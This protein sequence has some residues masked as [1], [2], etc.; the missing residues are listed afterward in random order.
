MLN[1]PLAQIQNAAKLSIMSDSG[2]VK[3]LME[4]ISPMRFVAGVISASST[5]FSFLVPETIT[6]FIF[7]AVLFQAMTSF[8]PPDHKKPLCLHLEHR[9]G[10]SLLLSSVSDSC[11][12]GRER[13]VR[14]GTQCVYRARC[15]HQILELEEILVSYAL[16]LYRSRNKGPGGWNDLPKLYAQ[17]IGGRTKIGSPK[18]LTLD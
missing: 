8:T 7:W 9:K 17:C 11:C 3:H 5:Y 15:K 1:N 4:S 2:N 10:T 16:P 12:D 13:C 14:W 18:F 6:V